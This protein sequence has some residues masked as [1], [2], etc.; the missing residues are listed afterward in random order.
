VLSSGSAPIEV[1]SKTV[2]TQE[3]AL[4]TLEYD[5]NNR[6]KDAVIRSLGQSN[7]D[8]LNDNQKAA[9]ISYTY[10]TGSG[11]LKSRGIKDAIV[12]SDYVSASNG[13][14]SGP[15]TSD[16]KVLDGL[17]RRRKIESMMFNKKV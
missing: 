7:W 6:F 9:L 15:T 12:K 3:T 14:L 4:L 5:V 8:K 11:T 13:I 1:T 17:V 2:F 10:N 16:R